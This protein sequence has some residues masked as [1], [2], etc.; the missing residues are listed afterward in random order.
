MAV[1]YHRISCKTCLAS[2][3]SMWKMLLSWLGKK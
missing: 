1:S 3:S 2:D